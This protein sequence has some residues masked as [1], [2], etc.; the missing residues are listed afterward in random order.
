MLKVVEDDGL[1][2]IKA[3]RT[4]DSTDYDKFV[5]EFQRIAAREPGTVPMVIEL[6]PDFSG[7]DFDGIWRDLKLDAKR[8]DSFGQIA[9]LGDD[10]WVEWGTML[11]NPLIRTEMKFFPPLNR[12]VAER[13]ASD[14]G[15]AA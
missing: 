9:T 4:L 7:W 8:K 10:K 6:A 1:V 3:E 14:E 5:P 12:D 15:N 13:W 11:S 2:R